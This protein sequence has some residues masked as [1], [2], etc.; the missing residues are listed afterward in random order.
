MAISLKFR[1]ALQV[2]VLFFVATLCVKG[3][4]TPPDS[5]SYLDT[6]KDEAVTEQVQNK[7]T[8]GVESYMQTILPPSP[9][10]A[11]L[12][13]FGSMPVSL[14]TG[15]PNIS[16][17]LYT[18]RGRELAVPISLDY[19]A[20]GIK[21]EEVASNVGLGWAL[22]AGGQITR[23]VRGQADG[24]SSAFIRGSFG[25]STF[26]DEVNGE[27]LPKLTACQSTS[28]DPQV[29]TEITE[30]FQNSY[31]LEPDIYHVSLPNGAN[32]SFYFD[33]DGTPT[34]LERSQFKIE[35]HP[36]L[37]PD[38]T[39]PYWALQ[40]V[41]LDDTGTR[42]YF[43]AYQSEYAA[44][45]TTTSRFLCSS[46]YDRHHGP[47]TFHLLRIESPSGDVITFKYQKY[48]L[49]YY[50]QE[51]SQ[52][53]ITH[54]TLAG[55]SSGT[56][57]SSCPLLIEQ[58]G[59]QL[60]KI[61]S[62][63][64]TV[65]F[66]ESATPRCDVYGQVNNN[67]QRQ[68]PTN[69]LK[70]FDYNNNL[71]KQVNFSQDY[72]NGC[73]NA[74]PYMCRLRLNAVDIVTPTSQR[75]AY[76]FQ[77]YESYP[78]PSRYDMGLDYW[79]YYNGAP[80][81]TAVPRFVDAVTG[82]NH[83]GGDR[84]PNIDYAKLGT[85]KQITYPTGGSTTFEYELHEYS[86]G[87]QGRFSIPRGAT[88]TRTLSISS[89]AALTHTEQI[90]LS[91]SGYGWIEN[92]T[93]GNGQTLFELLDNTTNQI[94]FSSTDC[95]GLN[96]GVTL[97]PGN[98]TLKLSFPL[99]PLGAS[100]LNFQW[101]ENLPN[102]QAKAGGLRLKRMIDHDGISSSNDITKTY[103]YTYPSGQCSGLMLNQLAFESIVKRNDGNTCSGWYGLPCCATRYWSKLTRSA[104]SMLASSNALG[105]S[106]VGYSYVIELHGNNE[107]FGKVEYQYLN[108]FIPQYEDQ[109][110]YITS[111]M[112][113]PSGPILPAPYVRNFT[114]HLLEQ[115]TFK[116]GSGSS[117]TLQQ[118]V[119]ND[120]H[121]DYSGNY[122]REQTIGV[123][124][125]QVELPDD[126]N[127]C[128]SC[129][130]NKFKR[131]VYTL[132]P[133]FPIK[134]RTLTRY[135]DQDDP[136]RYTEHETRYFYANSTVHPY[137][138]HV[139]TKTSQ[140]TRWQVQYSKGV[141]DYSPVSIGGTDDM[142]R[143]LRLMKERNQVSLPVEQVSYYSNTPPPSNP[144]TNPLSGAGAELRSSVLNLYRIH[145][146]GLGNLHSVL[147]EVHTSELDNIQSPYTPT[148]MSGSGLN[149]IIDN[150]NANFTSRVKF[151]NYNDYGNLLTQ[152]PMPSGQAISYIWGYEETLPIAEVLN[153]ENP[154][155][156]AHFN[157]EEDPAH[158]GTANSP[159]NGLLPK[160]GERFLNV[161]SLVSSGSG[162]L[163][164]DALDSEGEYILAFWH[165][166]AAGSFTIQS[167]GPTHSFNLPATATGEWKLFETVVSLSNGIVRIS[168]PTGSSYFLDDVRL[169]PVGTM[170]KTLTHDPLIGQTSET[171]AAYKIQYYEYD[172][173]NRLRLIRDQDRNILK[174]INYKF[175]NE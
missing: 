117:Y 103:Q 145:N 144:L 84:T 136:T 33:H 107:E 14:Y 111:I 74:A 152:K 99:A 11:A 7:S 166:G 41:L 141:V 27:V 106:P 123:I 138:T 48:W 39:T 44:D 29:E 170:M 80:N 68:K 79:G 64:G 143:A 96:S 149:F 36:L 139:Y 128:R 98:Y 100:Q 70:V 78:L 38:G 171:D 19:H 21:V 63:M 146:D 6:L 59:W 90:T 125:R 81:S 69:G 113:E 95:R 65:E 72:F 53:V 151:T 105:K 1:I 43:G 126:S 121:P 167:G 57:I 35:R 130:N 127:V 165:S 154:N 15:T 25:F 49:S 160:T 147:D 75:E 17:P 20:S 3:Q 23:E 109:N 118:H 28:S 115:K 157:F 86:N 168:F 4:I 47:T 77:Y 73:N 54:E 12:G 13:K 158:V 51:N 131:S 62:A 148:Y 163:V 91:N 8:T 119:L 46:L 97:A 45:E 85:I 129:H 169:H 102:L 89:T 92:C 60:Q 101:F 30:Y 93:Q 164:H 34:T 10:A 18:L 50:L 122:G 135:Y 156:A 32:F 124:Y 52:G 175:Y 37:P 114:G 56:S 22:N 150:A 137:P 110:S 71:I 24:P 140:D 94:I 87:A 162:E 61:N 31:D 5:T 142:T 16:I 134:T 76:T 67:S 88:Q 42:Y 132:E 116:K 173:L 58:N 161:S 174:R 112:D 26:F 155:N 133:V 82:D 159:V 55:H 40:W 9:N 120:Y 104:S 108:T 66:T 153:L 172:A 83:P 2:L